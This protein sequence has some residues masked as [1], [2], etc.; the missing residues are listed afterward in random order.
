M[1]GVALMLREEGFLQ[2][3]KLRVNIRHVLMYV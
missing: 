3:R 2:A 1:K